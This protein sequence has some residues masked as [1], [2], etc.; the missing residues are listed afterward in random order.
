[1]PSYRILTSGRLGKEFANFVDS[2]NYP[3]LSCSFLDFE[4][5]PVRIKDFNALAGFNFWDGLDIS[6]IKWIHSF[7][8]GLDSF[9]TRPDLPKDVLI[10]RTTGEL[11]RKMGEYCLA[12]I[13]EDLKGVITS[14]QY[15]TRNSW[16]KHT[17]GNLNEQSVLIFGT[18][19]IGGGVARVLRSIVG[20]TLGVNRSGYQQPEFNKIKRCGEWTASELRSVDIIINAMPLT[21]DTTHFFNHQ[22]FTQFQSTL[23]INV[24]RGASV[25]ENSLLQALDLGHIRRAILDVFED[26]PLPGES[27]LW[28]HP[29]ILITP[30]QSG[31]TDIEDIKDSFGQ[32]YETLKNVN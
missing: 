10:T 15:Q 2:F 8:A 32:S 22:V 20:N 19:A 5:V 24:G 12:Y 29:H 6:H 18:G 27:T 13:L 1:M 11:G 16:Q 25:D 4:E 26:E 30:H 31:V 7:G 21:A 17:Q 9:I 3:D 23:F 14:Y 28:N